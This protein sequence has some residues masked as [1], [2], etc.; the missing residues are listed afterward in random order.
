MRRARWDLV[1]ICLP[2]IRGLAWGIGYI[3]IVPVLQTRVVTEMRVVRYILIA[4]IVGTLCAF[5]ATASNAA[6]SWETSYFVASAGNGSI[7][8]SSE[9]DGCLPIGIFP[10]ITVE[11]DASYVEATWFPSPEFNGTGFAIPYWLVL[12]VVSLPWFILHRRER[13][14]QRR[15][16]I[17]AC[18]ACGYELTGNVSGRCPE[19]DAQVEPA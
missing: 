2:R 7:S 5:V 4:I 17:G 18:L 10:G 1:E 11:F 3:E 12:V 16:R 8:V 14:V 6:V 19:C 13:E 9:E 15:K